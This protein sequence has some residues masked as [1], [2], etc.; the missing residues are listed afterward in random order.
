MAKK[1][2]KNYS[3]LTSDEQKKLVSDYIENKPGAEERLY[4]QYANMVIKFA[5]KYSGYDFK[6]ESLVSE[7][8]IGLLKAAT[9]LF[10]LML[11]VICSGIS[12]TMWKI[13]EKKSKC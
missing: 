9:H 1:S 2:V 3:E 8:T 5:N 11:M 4:N 10:S 6:Q 12:A 7:A 13:T